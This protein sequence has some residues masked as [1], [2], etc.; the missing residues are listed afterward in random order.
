MEKGRGCRGAMEDSMKVR[1]RCWK[2]RRGG[3]KR[4]GRVR[5]K[6]IKEKNDGNGRKGMRDIVRSEWK[7]KGASWSVGR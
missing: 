6:E 2:G 4:L 7:G 3:K 5:G 1:K